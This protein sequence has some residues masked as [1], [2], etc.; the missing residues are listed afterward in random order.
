MLARMTRRLDPAA[1]LLQLISAERGE[2]SRI[3]RACKVSR[4][5]VHRWARR[6]DTPAPKRRD[7]LEKA[8]GG[9]IKA[10]W[11]LTPIETAQAHAALDNDRGA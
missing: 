10:F 9:K 8:T 7:R 1:T 3:A 11:W 5:Q 6:Q 2:A 4:Q